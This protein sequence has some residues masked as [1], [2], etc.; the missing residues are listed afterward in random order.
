MITNLRPIGRQRSRRVRLGLAMRT[1][2]TN[3]D[4]PACAC[5]DQMLDELDSSPCS[6]RPKTRRKSSRVPVFE[7]C[8]IVFRNFVICRLTLNKNTDIRSESIIVKQRF[9]FNSS[10]YCEYA[11]LPPTTVA[12]Q[13]RAAFIRFPRLWLPTLYGVTV[14]VYGFRKRATV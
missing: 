11:A 12:P 8:T 14:D 9:K 2:A 7:K 13:P 1:I 6:Q 4:T 10:L 3:E 5:V